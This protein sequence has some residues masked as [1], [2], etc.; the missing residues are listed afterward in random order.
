LR[1]TTSGG[2]TTGSS[3]S[4]FFG[5]DTWIAVAVVSSFSKL[6]VMYTTLTTAATIT[7]KSTAI[8]IHGV[9]LAVLWRMSLSLDGTWSFMNGGSYVVR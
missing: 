7:C 2:S 8:K 6:R 3:S 9:F 4:T 5:P 1:S